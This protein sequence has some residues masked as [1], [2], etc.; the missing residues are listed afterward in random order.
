MEI[1]NGMRNKVS[2]QRKVNLIPL[3]NNKSHRC[4]S[5]IMTLVSRCALSAPWSRRSY[6]VNDRGC[7]PVRWVA[8]YFR[9]RE[10]LSIVGHICTSLD[11]ASLLRAYLRID[12]IMALSRDSLM[13]LLTKLQRPAYRFVVNCESRWYARSGPTRPAKGTALPLATMQ[14]SLFNIAVGSK[15]G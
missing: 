14:N 11:A 3:E 5:H 13:R 1:T 12:L 4:P 9:I 8:T 6:N 15:A 7:R 10:V 2:G